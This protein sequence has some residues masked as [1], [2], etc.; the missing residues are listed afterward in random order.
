MRQIVGVFFGKDEILVKLRFKGL[1]YP[2]NDIYFDNQSPHSETV[3]FVEA[4]KFFISNS[5]RDCFTNTIVKFSC[6]CPAG[7]ALT[8]CFVLAFF[9][10]GWT[11]FAP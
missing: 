2:R 6:L 4:T 1:W 9:H 10:G 5:V 3:S 11:D 7:G 8:L